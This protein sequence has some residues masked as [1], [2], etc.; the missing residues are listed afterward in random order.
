V[1]I[2]VISRSGGEKGNGRASRWNGKVIG[3]TPIFSTKKLEGL[4]L[5]V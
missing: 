5:K 1:I 3:S 2:E 4:K